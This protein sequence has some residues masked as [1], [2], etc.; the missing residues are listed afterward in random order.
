VLSSQAVQITV[1]AAEID[2]TGEIVDLPSSGSYDR[3]AVNAV[4][5][6]GSPQNMMKFT[7]QT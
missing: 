4:M 1:G 7:L 3:N 5:L 2:G 6:Q